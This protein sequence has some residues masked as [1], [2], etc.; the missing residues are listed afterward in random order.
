MVRTSPQ[1]TK[2]IFEG[3]AQKIEEAWYDVVNEGLEE[4]VNGSTGT[5]KGPG[6]PEVRKR[7]LHF[8][9]FHPMIAAMENG[10]KIPDVSSVLIFSRWSILTK[11][12]RLAA[13]LHG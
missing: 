9:V 12:A 3:V 6:H 13:K 4:V 7:K 2:A 8:V 1:R 11:L 5:G 10:V